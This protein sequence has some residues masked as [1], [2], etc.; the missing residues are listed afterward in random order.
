MTPTSDEIFAMTPAEATA[1]LAEMAKAPPPDPA[2]PAGARAELNAKLADP[3]WFSR[4]TNGSVETQTE[5]AELTERG[6]AD[7]VDR[8]IDGTYSTTPFDFTDG[9]VSPH[10]A[11]G[12]AAWLRDAGVEPAAIKQLL[13]GHPVSKQELQAVEQHRARLLGDPEWTKRMLAGDAAARRDLL[14][15]SL[16]RVVGAES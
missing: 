12:A 11:M 13:E 16:L 4:Y 14:L 15:F 6:A 7:K 8:L 2:S 3:A 9:G 5:F 1:F 10:D